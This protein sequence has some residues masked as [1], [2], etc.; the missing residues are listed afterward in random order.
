MGISIPV[1]KHPEERMLICMRSK[2][3][4]C[5]DP[6]CYDEGGKCPYGED[7]GYYETF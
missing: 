5:D 6:K 1:K 4:W 3:G 2:D 7:E